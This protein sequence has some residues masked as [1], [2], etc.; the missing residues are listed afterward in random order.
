MKAIRTTVA[1]MPMA[2][3]S[4]RLGSPSSTR[5]TSTTIVRQMM[6][7]QKL[8]HCETERA[9]T[10]GASA[11]DGVALEAAPSGGEARSRNSPQCLHFLAMARITSPQKGQ[12]LVAS[13]A[14]S[15]GVAGAGSGT[16]LGVVVGGAG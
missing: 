6:Y 4:R 13:A 14:A 11:G 8:S 1:E 2:A 7:F 15:T 12:R 5:A 9:K 16:G 3:Y 10:G